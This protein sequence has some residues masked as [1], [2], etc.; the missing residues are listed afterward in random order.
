VYGENAPKR[1]LCAR[2]SVR[3]CSAI[4]SASL[5]LAA[6]SSGG[7]HASSTSTTHANQH[8]GSTV[9]AVLVKRLG[10]RGGAPKPVGVRASS[11]TPGKGLNPLA[12]YDC[13]LPK[14]LGTSLS[15][16]T[17]KQMRKYRERATQLVICR[18]VN[19]Q[20]KVNALYLVPG[21]DYTLTALYGGPGVDPKKWK[22]RS[23]T[24]AHAVGM[25][26]TTIACD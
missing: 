8:D 24:L 2:M 21:S 6:C 20:V 26:L 18:G 11:L 5:L 23:E 12:V 19:I 25:N 16:Y 22:E 1:A 9:A 15:A 13:A 10:C 17:P 4:L 7:G 3:F 14:G